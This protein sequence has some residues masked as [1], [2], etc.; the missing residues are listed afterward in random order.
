MSRSVAW[1]T[2][3]LAVRNS[4]YPLTAIARS[5]TAWTRA[6]STSVSMRFG[7]AMQEDELVPAEAGDELVRERGG[8]PLRGGTQHLVTGLM[9]DPVVDDLEPVEV[10]EQ[11]DHRIAMHLAA[12]QVARRAG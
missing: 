11:D 4:S 6:A 3:T 7:V 1:A 5:N 12:L 10:D 9:P 8:Q 2:P